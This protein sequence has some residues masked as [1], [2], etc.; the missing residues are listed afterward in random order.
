MWR[1]CT[2]FMVK[3]ISHTIDDDACLNTIPVYEIQIEYPAKL[4]C[5]EE[6]LLEE[7]I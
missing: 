5:L 2:L 1:N 7:F 6:E 3:C 4:D